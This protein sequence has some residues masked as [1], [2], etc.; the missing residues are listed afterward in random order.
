MHH[1]IRAIAL[2]LLASPALGQ[3]TEWTVAPVAKGQALRWNPAHQ[4]EV[5]ATWP[6]GTPRLVE[7]L[8]GRGGLHPEIA[9]LWAGGFYLRSHPSGGELDLRKSIRGIPKR[10]PLRLTTEHRSTMTSDGAF[11]W[12]LTFDAQEP[13][14]FVELVWTAGAADLFFERIEVVLPAGWSWSPEYPDPAHQGANLVR[15]RGGGGSWILPR[16]MSRPFLFVIHPTGVAPR[17]YTE[18]HKPATWSSGG[19]LQRDARIGA[20]PTAAWVAGEYSREQGKLDRLEH[21]WGGAAGQVPSRL[22]IGGGCRYGGMTS[23]FHR[24][25]LPHAAVA[26][27]GGRAGLGLIWIELLRYRTRMVDWEALDHQGLPNG[28]QLPREGYAGGAPLDASRISAA[29]AVGARAQLESIA[30]WDPIDAQHRDRMLRA[31]AP[32][33]WIFGRRIFRWYLIHDAWKERAPINANMGGRGTHVGREGANAVD[34]L[35]AAYAVSQGP[36]RARF[37]AA[38][39]RFERHWRTA[40]LPS[41]TP[42]IARGGVVVTRKP[43]GAGGGVALCYGFRG[44]EHNQ[45]L[46]SAYGL[47]RSTDIDATGLLLT[48]LRFSTEYAWRTGRGAP[49]G[50]YPLELL[51]GTT[52]TDPATWPTLLPVV[53]RQMQEQDQLQGYSFTADYRLGNHFGYAEQLGV[54]WTAQVLEH[55][56]RPDLAGAAQWVLALGPDDLDRYADTLAWLQAQPAPLPR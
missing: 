24:V 2:L 22:L 43:L 35:A 33:Y 1:L 53:W 31:T 3:I 38:L 25:D 10:C 37:R 28:A 14:V 30:A 19:Y 40:L 23:G 5:L 56:R 49:W 52:I 7:R 17:P 46:T 41:G 4:L 50:K 32:G 44:E 48:M 27:S 20:M 51:D 16:R 54:D 6:D 13:L 9:R 26:L 21:V 11:S 55:T 42:L 18:K 34:I 36:D 45:V 8:K 47:H 12:W 39:E 29:E 15:A